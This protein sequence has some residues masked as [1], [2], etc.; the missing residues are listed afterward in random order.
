MG[1]LILFGE[2]KLDSISGK[3]R[4]SSLCV[5]CH[6]GARK[7]QIVVLRCAQ[8]CC[9]DTKVINTGKKCNIRAGHSSALDTDSGSALMEKCLKPAVAGGSPTGNIINKDK[10]GPDNRKLGLY[11]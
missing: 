6:R 10:P 8:C 1:V 2:L 4:L 7:E 5:R 3:F 11:R 9:A